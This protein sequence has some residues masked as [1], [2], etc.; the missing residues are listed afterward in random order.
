LSIARI[1]LLMLTPSPASRPRLAPL[2]AA[3]RRGRRPTPAGLG[4]ERLERRDLMALITDF[5]PRFSTN[6]TGD[7][8][9]AANTLMTAPP[10][11]PNAANAQNRVGN[12]LNNN[13]FD[14]VWVDIDSDPTTFNSSAA[15]LNLPDDS[16]V[17]FAGLYWGAESPSAARTSVKLRSPG[18]TSYTAV[19]GKVIGVDTTSAPV[20]QNYQA[21]AD[22]TAQ[23]R[24][25]GAGSY[26][27]AN[28]QANQGYN[29]YAG[30]SLVVAYSS[31]GQPARNLTIFDGY[32]AV[33]SSSTPRVNIPVSGFVA[34]PTGAVNARVGFVAYEGDAG[35]S[36][37]SVALDNTVLGNATNPS[38]N[39]F[40]SAISYLGSY[41]NTKTPNY[42]NQ[43]GYDEAI[44]AANGVIPNSATSA[45][46]RLT[47]SGDTYFPGVVTTAI[48][49]YAPRVEADKSVA[50][51]S[52]GAVVRPGD[53]LRYTVTVSN[54]GQDATAQTV[55]TDDI[56]EWATY[57]PGSL[58][59]T[60]GP[61]A[62]PK[63]DAPGDDQAWF[64]PARDRV[65]F[66][67]GQG[68][69]PSMGGSIPIGGSTTITF[70]VTVDT[71]ADDGTLILNQSRIDY[72]AA[73]S[74]FP[75][76]TWSNETET[77]VVTY[78]ADLAVT[79]AVDDATP[80]V[81]ETVTFTVGLSNLGPDPTTGVTLADALPDGLTYIS[82]M[83]PVGTSYN[84]A[85]G[86]WTVGAMGVGAA[87]ART[88]V[89]VA[90]VDSPLSE[91]NVATIT[92][93]DRTDPNPLNNSASATVTPL[94]ADLA[95]AKTVSNPS[96]NV[97]QAV[98][99]T[100][101]AS[102]LGPNG[103]TGVS[104]T[105]SLPAG[106][107]YISHA[108]SAGSSY[109]SGTGVWTIGALPNGGVR[110]LT[111]T[112]QVD[113][114][115]IRLNTAAV[116][117]SNQY[118]PNPGNNSASA[119]VRPQRA[120]LGV[121]KTVSDPTPNV[122]DTIVYTVDLYNNGPDP[123]TNVVLLDTFPAD[124]QFVSATAPTGTTYDDATRIWSVPQIAVG[125]HLELLIT[126][127]V[128]GASYGVNTAAI[129]ASDQYDPN[130]FNN[131]DSNSITPQ[132]ADL[133]VL[134]RVNNHRPDVGAQVT[135]T[136][137]L[138]NSGPS[139]ATGVS[140]ADTLPAGLAYVSH[141][142]P[143]G[144]TY[145]PGTGLWTVGA[146]L[147][148]ATATLTITAQVAT[149][150]EKINTAAVA[151]SDQFDP[152]PLNN[153]SSSWVVPLEADLAV[154]KS[155]DDERPNVSQVVTFHVALS[156]LG[157]DPASGV[158]VSDLLPAGLA[159]IS[160][161]AS[162]GSTY[163]PATGVWTVT[164]VVD[165]SEPL[166]LLLTASVDGPSIVTNT[167][168][169]T[170][171]DRY[172]PN[173]FNNSASAT[174]HPLVADLALAKSVDDPTPNVGDLI[175]YT[176]SLS[177]L[178]P[179]PATGILVGDLLPAGI[180]FVAADTVVG[181]YDPTLDRWTVD[182]LPSG[183]T[184]TLIVSARV[185]APGT[186]VNTARIDHADTYDPNLANN[187]A[188]ATVVP[189]EAT[190]TV[191]KTVDNPTATAGQS[192]TFTVTVVNSGPDTATGVELLDVL[193][194]RFRLV[195]FTTSQGEFD[196]NTGVWDV[197]SIAPGASATLTLTAV[198]LVPVTQSNTAT[199]TGLDQY[200]PDTSGWVS[201]AVVDPGAGP[202]VAALVRTGYHSAPS[203]F[204]IT[205]ST[206]MDEASV[207]N[208]ANY[209]LNF[210]GRRGQLG[211]AI[212]F[213]S[214]TYDADRHTVTLRPT[215]NLPVF[216]R[217]QLVINGSTVTGVRNSSGILL[218]GAG[219]GRS[220]TDYVRRWYGR[221]IIALPRAAVTVNARA[222][223]ALS[224]LQAR[225]LV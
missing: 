130:P 60:S 153:Q 58:V 160:H 22:V 122:G 66:D 156:N 200:T 135:F 11:D 3:R 49:L 129:T 9:I 170:A 2:T 190:L 59:I 23:V 121:L 203:S 37:D 75:L 52:G 17:L 78:K 6:A 38:N 106:L 62:G 140:L 221:E 28:V 131:Q 145:D 53:T 204:V 15:T 112:A 208:V 198:L 161:T 85:T 32:G 213:A 31:P 123:A 70:N 90:R 217:Y 102:N 167:A 176:I 119:A 138:I 47:T 97:G 94:Q 166:Y 114:P 95:V 80:N 179:D 181:T 1:T 196:D 107:T 214:A 105:D 182:V 223:R 212:A 43:L 99:F 163:D 29:H 57:V 152:N 33:S 71:D 185:A 195:G 125:A 148:D 83:A 207:E 109:D 155:V 132:E 205:Y 18:A 146:L 12:K 154:T 177:N 72:D 39:F 25:S 144:T 108:A 116:A 63:T 50:N 81:G 127:L 77:L 86:V 188:S 45:V 42:N 118:D 126:A 183:L 21:F 4:V 211:P 73:T 13:D 149:P 165:P 115:I 173:P 87:L 202:T 96:P 137:D 169:I 162:P 51:L 133:A 103:A 14:M 159:Y 16:T 175:Q 98:T 189:Q 61:N 224:R 120:D 210:L 168:T 150:G 82:H 88:L 65:V 136:I 199:I 206:A 194:A 44:V 184:V 111:L 187:S 36:G 193:E 219:N 67:L 20:G 218:D 27:M 56:P 92:H 35:L 220:G 191:T 68:A 192:V 143:L 201:T 5:T 124:V 10:W 147:S 157:P 197:G 55:L 19:T 100:I 216:R 164:G 215:R 180:Q 40:N 30:W 174:I 76:N 151:S 117:T 93:S 178:G 134:K 46:V 209:R 101:T 48:D 79:K 141:V 41:V 64:D 186:Q 139:D 158:V 74:G 24:A 113:V 110:T 54:D 172:D 89:L 128:T 7:I 69:T 104:L 26:T 142:A 34:P 171:S 84:P 222:A 91:T 225:R 8:T